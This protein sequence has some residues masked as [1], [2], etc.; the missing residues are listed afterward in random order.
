MIKDI[1]ELSEIRKKYMEGV[2]LNKGFEDGIK[3]LLTE[4]YPDNAHFI[5]ELLQNAEDALSTEVRFILKNDGVEF[6][7]NGTRL[8]SI[9]D[10]ESI[11]SIG[12]ST[13]KNDPTNIG[14]FGVGFKAVFAYT[15]TPEIHSGDFHFRIRDMVV[16]EMTRPLLCSQ[17]ERETQFIFPFN[18]SKKPP[19]LAR[20]EVERNLR[21]LGENTLLFLSNI[22]KIEYLLPDA[23]L[24]YLKRNKKN[25]NRIEILV[26]HPD[27]TE[28]VSVVFLRFEKMVDV[29]DEDGNLKSCKISIAFN[30]VENKLQKEEKVDKQS[31]KKNIAHWEIKPLEPGRVS[32]YFPADKETSNLRFHLN[33]PFASTVARDSVRDC[34]SNDILRN[35]LAEFIGESMTTIRDQGLLA[36]GFLATLPN[37]KDNL[38]PFYKPIQN[39]LIE[40][41]QNNEL[42]P[43]KRGGHAA[44]SGIFRGPAQLSNLINDD[45]LATILGEDYFPPMWVANPPQKNQRED[46]FLSMLNISEWTI[47]NL[48]NALAGQSEPIMKWLAEK[49]DGWH[50]QLYL[51]LGD[52]LS[53]APSSPY[54]EA[55]NRKEKLAEICI[56]RLSDGTYSVGCECYFPSDGVEHDDLIPRV[57]K[58]VYTSG[59]NEE[60]KKKAKD[61]LEKIGVRELGEVEQ[62]EAILKS[63][64]SQAAADNNTFNPELK[65]LNRFIALVEKDSSQANLF[66]EHFIFKLADG[67]WGKPC[68]AYLDSP[69]LETGL[70]TYYEALCDDYQCYGLSQEY[71]KCG[72][73]LEKISD[74]AKKVGAIYEL[75]ISK[76]SCYQNPEWS[77]LSGA[78]GGYG[79]SA[80]ND[81]T[82]YNLDKLLETPDIELSR[83]IWQTM[84][85][86]D[87]KFLQAAYKKS[88]KG[89]FRYADS[90]LVHILINASWIPQKEDGLIF[91]VQPRDA[92]RDKL[93]TGFIYLEVLEW[94][95]KVEFGKNAKKQTEEFKNFNHYAKELGF[96][97]IDEAEKAAELVKRCREEGRSLD[98]ILSQFSINEKKIKPK[99]PSKKSSNSERREDKISKQYP[100]APEKEYEKKTRSIRTSKGTIDPDTYL[101]SKYTNE[102]E[103]MICQICKEVMPFK[104]RNREHYFERVEVLSKDLKKEHEAQFLALCPLCAAMYKEFVKKDEASMKAFKSDLINSEQPEISLTLGDKK[105]SI[106][107]V[108]DHWRDIRTILQMEEE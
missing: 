16:P 14:K 22:R 70:T 65:E 21:G 107:F 44:A 50:Q 3:R 42:T 43:M 8:F 18:N 68:Q 86:L 105:T 81:Y 23:S 97:S 71:K 88:D 38:S 104:K 73:G 30:M 19:D 46:N 96:E 5:Y 34:S 58:G 51:L 91:F 62:V 24:G 90:Q 74:F 92:F 29:H 69:F 64:Y 101:R 4:L 100:E 31:K 15:D 36:V 67:D 26:Q 47:E 108:E 89:G 79:N 76:T 94:F 63:R 83:L 41:F 59:K 93:P 10:V 57:A 28:P 33:A 54:Y 75:P 49:T 87:A 78:S 32:I 84:N 17:N 80:N 45:D 52:F 77:Y 1:Q 20:K 13:K 39:S 98:E 37:D 2:R 95:T 25:R 11:T 85:C 53:N 106:Q 61:F 56:V 82:I 72:I 27:Q 40:F 55:R 7:H 48:I 35:H 6:E 60:H 103:E 12:V 9:D 66:I 99:F 102:E